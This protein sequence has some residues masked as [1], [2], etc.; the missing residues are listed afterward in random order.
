[1]ETRFISALLFAAL[2]ISIMS[3]QPAPP[4]P[5][6][7]KTALLDSALTD[8][9]CKVTFETGFMHA[10]IARFPDLSSSLSPIIEELQ[11]DVTRLSQ[12]ASQKDVLNY[13]IYVQESFT[14]HMM[15]AAT[16]EKSGIEGQRDSGA[17]KN[18]TKAAMESLKSKFDSLKD[19]QNS[20]FDAKDHANLVINYYNN[21]LNMYEARTKNLTDRG[22]DTS[23]LLTLVSDARSQIL[24]P[25]Q[26]GVNSATDSTGVI[27][28]LGQYCLF[29]GC[30]DGTNFHMAAKFETKRLTILLEVISPTA[31]EAGLDRDTPNTSL[32]HANRMIE[33]WG[34]SNAG[35]DQLKATWDNIRSAAKDLHDL[36]V[37]LGGDTA[38]SD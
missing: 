3:A 30:L 27:D 6:A 36:F 31:V 17:D 11:L 13:S 21:S 7:D 35:G 2:L 25:L 24:V 16:A 19:A 8:M 20:C 4:V 29:D 22:F 26:N 14:P 38:L 5:G 12:Y 23:Y 10:I 28:V 33:S 34:T 1:M 9:K 37:A 18:E 15:T 32:D